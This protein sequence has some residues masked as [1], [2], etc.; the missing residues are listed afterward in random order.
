MGVTQHGKCTVSSEGYAWLLLCVMSYGMLYNTDLLESVPIS[1]RGHQRNVVLFLTH[2]IR[3]SATTAA[4]RACT[5]SILVVPL[6]S[7][8]VVVFGV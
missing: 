7:C 2:Q 6:S 8:Q 1:F 4:D 3:M 5:M